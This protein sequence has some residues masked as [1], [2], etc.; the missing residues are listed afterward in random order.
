MNIKNVPNKET[1]TYNS[2]KQRRRFSQGEY[3]AACCL[4]AILFGVFLMAKSA[5]TS[6]KMVIFNEKVS[7]DNV[8]FSQNKERKKQNKN[9]KEGTEKDTFYIRKFVIK[10]NGESSTAYYDTVKCNHGSPK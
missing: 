4:M 2:K 1:K 5:F 7:Y 9:C 8:D 3:C 10:T 6:L